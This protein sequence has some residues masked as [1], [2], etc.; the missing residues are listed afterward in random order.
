MMK[1]KSD[2]QESSFCKMKLQNIAITIIFVNNFV[3]I[4]HFQDSFLMVS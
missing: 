3:S 1:P 2:I 4:L